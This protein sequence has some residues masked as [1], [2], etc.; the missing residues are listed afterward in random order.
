MSGSKVL[1]GLNNL[2]PEKSLSYIIENDQDYGSKLS[3]LLSYNSTGV[4]MLGINNIR[5]YEK[6]D[7]EIAEM[8]SYIKEFISKSKIIDGSK[9]Q[10]NA[11]NSIESILGCGEPRKYER[12]ADNSNVLELDENEM[13]I[14]NTDKADQIRSEEMNKI[15][16]TNENNDISGN[17][18]ESEEDNEDITEEKDQEL[19]ECLQIIDTI[20][21]S[22]TNT[23]EEQITSRSSKMASNP[24]N[25]YFENIYE[26]S[27][28]TLSKTLAFD[29]FNIDLKNGESLDLD[30]GCSSEYNCDSKEC[31]NDKDANSALEVTFFLDCEAELELDREC[32]LESELKPEYELEF[33]LEPKSKPGLENELGLELDLEPEPEPEPETEPETEPVPLSEP[34]PEYEPGLECRLEPG[35]EPEPGPKPE[36]EYKP[37]KQCIKGDNERTE[38]IESY[39][40][41][42]N[43]TLILTD[44]IPVMKMME[45]EAITFNKDHEESNALGLSNE[46][47]WRMKIEN[48]MRNN[49]KSNQNIGY[50][51]GKGENNASKYTEN[52]ENQSQNSD[53]YLR[54]NILKSNITTN[55]TTSTRITLSKASNDVNHHNLLNNK[56]LKIG[57]IKEIEEELR[58]CKLS[59]NTKGS[60]NLFKGISNLD[61]NKEFDSSLDLNFNLNLELDLNFQTDLDHEFVS[62]S[63]YEVQQ[64]FINKFDSKNNTGINCNMPLKS[65]KYSATDLKTQTSIFSFENKKLNFG[66]SHLNKEINQSNRNS[67]KVYIGN[68]DTKQFEI[69][70]S[71]KNN[72]AP[73]REISLSKSNNYKS[74]DE[75]KKIRSED[76]VDLAKT[77]NLSCGANEELDQSDT[78]KTPENIITAIKLLAVVRDIKRQIQLIKSQHNKLDQANLPGKDFA[79]ARQN[80]TN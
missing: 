46:K 80:L 58:E 60:P 64:N 4:P 63:E 53:F 5:F 28:E 2:Q 42:N 27:L 61:L 75:Y 50:A 52:G 1:E 51:V 69:K 32:E 19:E 68:V 6:M 37:K 78:V 59:L 45:N 48:I 21:V 8:R 16:C 54:D 33:E 3:K 30:L 23:V 13:T 22:R 15:S 66:S 40:S 34:V 41:V 7:G 11:C 35:L 29:Q 14:R 20:Q 26:K 70:L 62:E 47:K 18:S 72:K 36:L 67:N 77:L 76:S 43:E 25:L 31:F 24:L 79:R 74:N 12:N 55:S 17:G 49:E 38:T 56:D 10:F 65:H 44:E 57:V 39:L 9:V 73:N 71:N